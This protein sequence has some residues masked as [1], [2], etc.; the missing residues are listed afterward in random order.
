LATIERAFA[1]VAAAE[2]HGARAHLRKASEEL[3]AGR[4]AD[5]I[6]ESIQSKRQRGFCRLGQGG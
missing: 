1:D 2:F 3:T 5:S 4:Y 6:R